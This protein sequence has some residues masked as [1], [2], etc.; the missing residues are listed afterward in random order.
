MPIAEGFEDRE[1]RRV[2]DVDEG[3]ALSTWR[4]R[5][6]SSDEV[7]RERP[8]GARAPFAFALVGRGPPLA[9]RLATKNRS[10]FMLRFGLVVCFTL[11][12][13]I[14]G[15]APRSSCPPVAST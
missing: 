15:C 10:S 3:G 5:E 1:K 4:A 6:V 12:S 13:A 8:V 7:T 14:L 11:A 2:P 9:H